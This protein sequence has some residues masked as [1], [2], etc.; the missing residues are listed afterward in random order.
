MQKQKLGHI[1]NIASVAGFKVFAPGGTVYRRD[2]SSPCGALTE[3]P[4]A[5]SSR[6]DNI[7]CNRDLSCRGLQRNYPKVAR[8]KPPERI[9]ASSTK[10]AISAGVNC[11]RDKL[12]PSSNQ[13][14]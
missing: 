6:A 9:C 5:W 2:E 1:I 13:P 14:T 4:C 12:T 11:S 8:K 3:G 10:I 7:R